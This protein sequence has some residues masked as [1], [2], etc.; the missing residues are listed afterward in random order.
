M[1]KYVIWGN[2]TLYPGSEGEYPREDR[3]E[4]ILCWRCS[5]A[6]CLEVHCLGRPE[7]VC[8]HLVRN[9]HPLVYRC[10]SKSAI[11]SMG[12]QW[13][14]NKSGILCAQAGCMWRVGDLQKEWQPDVNPLARSRLCIGAYR[15][16]QSTGDWAWPMDTGFHVESAME[17]LLLGQDCKIAEKP[18]SGPMTGAE[19]IGV[20]SPTAVSHAARNCKSALSLCSILPVPSIEKI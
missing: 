2:S 15:G 16:S 1:S 18:C 8:S 5:S 12:A 14:C 10:G 3:L 19:F 4:E 20:S 11:N 13:S 7:L 9:W 17:R 6:H